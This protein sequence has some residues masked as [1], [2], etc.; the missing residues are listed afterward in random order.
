MVMSDLWVVHQ[1]LKAEWRCAT[2]KT[3][4]LSVTVASVDWK[5]LWSAVSS[6]FQDFVSCFLWLA[7]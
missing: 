2:M 3:G 7:I 6:D 4:A 1:H 5:Q